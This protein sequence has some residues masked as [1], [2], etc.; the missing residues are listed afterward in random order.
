ML[1]FY[2]M[3]GVHGA[4]ALDEPLVVHL[5]GHRTYA[6]VWKV[7]LSGSGAICYLLEH[8]ELFGAPTVYVGP[9]GDSRSNAYRFAFLSRAAIDLCYHLDWIPDVLHAHDWATGLAPVYLNTSEVGRPM[10]AAAS[11]LT[12]HNMQHQGCFERE[13][14]QYAGLPESLF[15]ADGLESWGQVNMLKG[16]IYHATKITT[17]SPT[18]A[19]EIQQ[20]AGG[21]GSTTYFHYRAGD[22]IGVLNGVDVDEWDPQTDPHLPRNY[23][24][25][26]LSGKIECKANCRRPSISRSMVKTALCGRLATR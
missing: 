7:L 3:N 21:M 26:D 20:V 10:G 16:G 2:E 9:T 19:A 6:R 23:S 13:L 8:N 1:P 14:L 15:R 25:S 11:V 22:L 18:Y 24:A 17:V 12:L 5:G 4:E